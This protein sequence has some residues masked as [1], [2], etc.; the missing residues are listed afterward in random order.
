[1]TEVKICGITN[2]E[3]ALLAFECG[4]DALGF[5][6]HPGSPRYLE[7]DAVRKIIL[8]LPAAI[9]KVGVFVNRESHVVRGMADYCGL[10]II[11]LHGDETLA[12]CQS[13][14][15]LSVIKAVAGFKE[16]DLRRLAE[17]PVKA[18]LVDSRDAER[19]GGTG[20]TSDWTQAKK[21]REFSPLILAGGLN[22]GNI[23]E[24]I[25]TVSPDAVDIASGVE[26]SPGKKDP[27]K[28]KELIGIVRALD[29]PGRTPI[30][31]K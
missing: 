30:F 15:P 1:M 29:R 20:Q 18:F 14:P 28:M 31:R 4:A 10:D 13:F 9:T 5:V 24:A 12:Y 21:I 19:Y 22:A 3:D 25:E 27:E 7:S 8:N 2:R 23:R 16:I 26:I 17:Y 6:F 11:Q